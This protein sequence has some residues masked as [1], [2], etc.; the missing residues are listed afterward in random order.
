[1]EAMKEKEQPALEP[2]LLPVTI[3]E[4][5]NTFLLEKKPLGLV[6]RNM[7]LASQPKPER[8]TK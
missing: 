5:S 8:E 2:A 6:S 4:S 3:E 1:M 7:E